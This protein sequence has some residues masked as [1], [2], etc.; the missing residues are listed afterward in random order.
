ML[1]ELKNIADNGNFKMLLC[2]QCYD[3]LES[4]S[5]WSLLMLGHPKVKFVDEGTVSQ[6]D[7]SVCG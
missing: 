4:N 1:V 7:S 5:P 3:S 6:K 2:S